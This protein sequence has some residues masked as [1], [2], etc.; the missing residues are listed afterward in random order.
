MA[1]SSS[2]S[3]RSRPAPAGVRS[4]R[5]RRA[6]RQP[7]GAHR[8]RFERGLLLGGPERLGDQRR[9]GRRVLLPVRPDEQ[10]RARPP[11]CSRSPRR[12][13][14]VHI[15]QA[16]TGLQAFTTYHYRLVVTGAAAANTVTFTTP[17]I[18]LSV[19]I[20][21]VPNPVTYGVALHGRGHALRHRRRQ[22]RG[23]AAVQP[24]PVHGPLR[25]VRQPAAHEPHG[26]VRVPG[27][28]GHREHA[29]AG[30]HGRPDP[31]V[32]PGRH[33]AG[34]GA[35]DDARPQH[36]PA[37]LRAAVR[38]R[39]TGR[40]RRADRLPARDPAVTAPRTSA[41]RSSRRS[42]PRG[43]SSAASCGSTR[44]STRRSSRSPTAPTC[45]PPACRSWFASSPSFCRLR[46][47]RRPARW[48]ITIPTS[49]VIRI[50]MISGALP[51]PTTQ[52]TLT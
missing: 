16:I 28:R 2:N 37:G 33:R 46:R 41:A 32:Q 7:P 51:E 49:S 43:R 45:P 3:A 36:P 18:P 19:A 47:E 23:D 25:P 30:L 29:A 21:A 42:P 31:R 11:R 27:A 17:K 6:R 44:A 10:I 1:R 24:V 5:R 40:G 38:N 34:R 13:R 20:V 12:P 8:S 26:W 9:A 4:R 48:L 39:G 50:T 14:K 52:L 15:S 35:G 22:P